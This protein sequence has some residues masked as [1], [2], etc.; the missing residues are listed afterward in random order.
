MRVITRAHC[1]GEARAMLR[2]VAAGVLPQRPSPK[3]PPAR[4]TSSAVRLANGEAAVELHFGFDG[5]VEVQKC[6]QLLH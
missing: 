2:L 5:L 3:K 6:Q 1:G 4:V